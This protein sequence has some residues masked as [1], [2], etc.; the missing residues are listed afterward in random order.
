MDY[1]KRTFIQTPTF[2]KKWDEAGLTDDDLRVLEN[3]ILRDPKSSPAIRGTGGIRKIRIPYGN[4]G[5]RGGGRVIYVDID[6]KETI[7]LLD[8]YIKNEKVDL[9][10]EEKK[11]LK[12]LVELLR[13]G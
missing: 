12:K 1:S 4:N 3:I 8:I 11:V 5:K 10:V 13:E 6:I 7:Y 2:S 9:S